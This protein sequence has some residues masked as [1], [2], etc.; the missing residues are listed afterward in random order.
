MM[1]EFASAISERRPAAT[2]GRWGLR[3]MTVLKR[4]PGASRSTGAFV[5]VEECE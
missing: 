3:V 2:D 1:A 4:P 5:D